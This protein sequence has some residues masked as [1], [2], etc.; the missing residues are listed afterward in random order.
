MSKKNQALYPRTS[1]KGPFTVEASGYER[2]EGETIPRRHP[3]SK[4]KLRTTPSDDVKTMFDILKRSADKFGNAKAVGSR[5]YI[6]THVENKKVKKIVDG[7]TQEVD[8]K[9]TYFELSEYNY[10][11][12]VEYEKMALEI[13]AGLR[14]LGLVKG[15]RLHL[16][17]GT[18]S[19]IG[20][21]C[22]QWN[23]C[24]LTFTTTAPTGWPCPTA[25]SRSQ[26]P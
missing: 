12:F 20:Y 18:R 24:R 1:A 15:D 5:R 4:D 21:E 2:R 9:W 10:I 16:F 23:G 11:S 22:V 19:V 6:K 14:K 7:E 26:Y 3:V 13:G 25:P 8:K 17:A